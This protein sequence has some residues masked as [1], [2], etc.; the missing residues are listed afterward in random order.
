MYKRVDFVN[1]G[2]GS[3]RPKQSY[4]EKISTFAF[5][6]STMVADWTFRQTMAIILMKSYPLHAAVEGREFIL[7]S[8]RREMRRF[9]SLFAT[10]LKHRDDL[11][12]YLLRIGI[13][14]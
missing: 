2:F 4:I 11:I 3:D 9:E 7:I 14:A 1:V 13:A 10:T 12:A 8:Q 6:F 5:A